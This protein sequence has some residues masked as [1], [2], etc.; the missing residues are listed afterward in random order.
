MFR[1]LVLEFPQPV[2]LRKRFFKA[3]WD[4]NGVPAR[5]SHCTIGFQC[6]L[7]TPIYSQQNFHACRT[8]VMLRAGR[9]TET[10]GP[11][12]PLPHDV[13]DPGVQRGR[14]R[15]DPDPSLGDESVGRCRT[16]ACFLAEEG[17][18][19][20]TK[21]K[22]GRFRSLFLANFWPWHR[23]TDLQVEKERGWKMV[24]VLST[25]STWIRGQE[26]RKA[27]SEDVVARSDD[28]SSMFSVVSAENHVKKIKKHLRQLRSTSRFGNRW[29]EGPP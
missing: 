19:H 22:K 5:L 18:G 7:H 15:C 2:S 21:A 29:K 8:V 23:K 10:T 14:R 1:Y 27:S 12:E 20:A 17:S 26:L 6:F 25:W 28:V 13:Q 11:L 3:L 24:F 16:L 9:Q 4:L